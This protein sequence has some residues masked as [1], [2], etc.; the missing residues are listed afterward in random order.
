VNVLTGNLGNDTYFIGSGDTVV[1]TSSLTTEID[2]VYSSA[3]YTLSAN[4]EKLTLTGTAAINGTG[5]ELANRLTGNGADNTLTGDNGADTFIGG[6]GKDTINLIET[7][8]A[9]D[10]V[11]IA[12]GDSLVNSNDLVTN[13]T[14]G[15]DVISTAGVDKLDLV[16]TTIAANTTGV[17]GSD[18]GIIHSHSINNGIIRFDDIDSYT[19]PLTITTSVLSN[20]LDYLQA[21]ITEGNTV[22][23]VSQGNTFVFQDGG[24]SDT[25]LELTGVIANSVNTSGLAASAVWLV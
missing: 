21:N 17:D 3:T 19:S 5:N 23:F 1:E 11:C 25:L 14:L 24:V 10:T 13:F 18:A 2:S 4:V 16:T 12:A 20:V 15:T 22:A 6:L 7:I 8:A 9:S